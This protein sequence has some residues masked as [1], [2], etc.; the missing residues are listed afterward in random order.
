[1]K[2]VLVFCAALMAV[3]FSAKAEDENKIEFAYEAGFEG[4]SSYLWRGQYNGGLSFQQYCAAQG[5]DWRERIDEMAEVQE[6]A[7][8]KGVTLSFNVAENSDGDKQG[9][10]ETDGEN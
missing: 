10:D 8:S 7:E 2:K 9:D 5:V 6:Y 4:V 3:V 1:M